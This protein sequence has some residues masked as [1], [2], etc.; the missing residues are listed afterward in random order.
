[1]IYLITG[2]AGTGKST[3]SKAI[4]DT[5]YQ[6]GRDVI[7]IDGDHIRKCWPHLKFSQ[8]HRNANLN[9]ILCMCKALQNECD[10]IIV[11][12]VAPIAEARDRF[13]KDI[14]HLKELRL[15]K[16]HKRRP[17]HYYCEYEESWSN[18]PEYQNESGLKQLLEEIDE[19]YEKVKRDDAL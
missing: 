16:I 7:C 3:A 14:I 2:H 5:L 13:Y 10:D 15:T 19:T 11:S 4:R 8:E 17:K 1:M 6:K 18:T 9:R 12:V